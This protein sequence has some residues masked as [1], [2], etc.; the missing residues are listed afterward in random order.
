MNLLLDTQVFIWWR[1]NP[2][3]ILDNVRDRIATTAVVFVSVVSVWEA[4][5]KAALGKL[6]DPG[7]FTAAVRDSGMNRLSLGFEQ[8]EMSAHLPFHHKDP[9]D[10]ALIAQA[11]AEQL[12]IVTTDRMFE[13]YDVSLMLT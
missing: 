9:F 4:A 13:K 11:K 6:R 3:R 1:A 8:A 7:S 12:T 2:D 10:R 5:I